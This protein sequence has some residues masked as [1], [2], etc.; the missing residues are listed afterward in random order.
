MANQCLLTTGNFVGEQ[1]D[2]AFLDANFHCRVCG[3]L[4]GQHP[5]PVPAGKSSYQ[6]VSIT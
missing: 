5:Q 2:G 3:R 6:I 1:A 4:A